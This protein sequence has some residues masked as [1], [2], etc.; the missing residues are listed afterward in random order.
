MLP[1]PGKPGVG[2]A[3]R[4]RLC[5]RKYH[6]R[7][8]RQRGPC[9]F[10][11]VYMRFWLVSVLGSSVVIKRDNGR[12]ASGT[13]VCRCGCRVRFTACADVGGIWLWC[14]KCGMLEI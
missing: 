13:C 2:A 5:L 4:N 11:G 3:G 1:S 14:S 9:A 7:A 12:E 6:S 10:Q 8:P